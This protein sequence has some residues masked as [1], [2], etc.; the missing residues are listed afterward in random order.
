LTTRPKRYRVKIYE[1]EVSTHGIFAMGVKYDDIPGE[2][3]TQAI[4]N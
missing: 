4:T 2:E 1:I 3:D